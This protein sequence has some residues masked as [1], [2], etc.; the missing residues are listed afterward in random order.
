MGI[1]TGFAYLFRSSSFAISKRIVVYEGQCTNSKSREYVV[2]N[3]C[4]LSTVTSMEYK[5]TIGGGSRVDLIVTRGLDGTSVS[6]G[7]GLS[8]TK[9]VGGGGGGFFRIPFTGAFALG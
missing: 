6:I 9:L 3:K 8:S 5:T 4:S 2:V 7:S 1:R